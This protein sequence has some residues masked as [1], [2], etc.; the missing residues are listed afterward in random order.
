MLY[1]RVTL[2]G[3]TA[4]GDTRYIWVNVYDTAKRYGGPEEGGWWFETGTPI[5]TDGAV[6]RCPSSD[7]EHKTGF[8]F[9]YPNQDKVIPCPVPKMITAGNLIAEGGLNGWDEQFIRKDA[10]EPEHRGE[11]SSGKRKVRIEESRGKMYPQQW[12]HYE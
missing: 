3:G 1:N 2:I 10:E 7:S 6:C 11:R 8:R 12:P 5:W 4:M 9:D